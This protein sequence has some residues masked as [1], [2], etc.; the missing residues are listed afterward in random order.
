VKV[1][2]PLSELESQDIK[3]NKAY[4][5]SC[6][7]SRASDL[8]AAAKVFKNAARAN[9]GKIPRIADGVEFYIA[10]ASQPEQLAAEE[11]GDWQ[12]MLEAGAKPLPAEWALHRAW[13]RPF[14]TWGSWDKCDKSEL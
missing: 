4:L 6:T 2:T 12:A 9:S 8:A 3:V 13:Y 1:A 7:N 5:V 11:A 10:A 14:R